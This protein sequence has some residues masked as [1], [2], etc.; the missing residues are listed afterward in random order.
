MRHIV[1]SYL[2]LSTVLQKISLLSSTERVALID[3]Q[4]AAEGKSFKIE[5][6]GQRNA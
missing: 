5:I 2:D 4:P 1:Y 3:S 6:A